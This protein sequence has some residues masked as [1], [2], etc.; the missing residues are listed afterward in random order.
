[1]TQTGH[2]MD[3]LAHDKASEV[4]M[5][6]ARNPHI[7]PETMMLLAHDIDAVRYCLAQNRHLTDAVM[8]ILARE[9]DA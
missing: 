3:I 6:L 4:R 5:A 1:M 7:T 9:E 8:D 2:I